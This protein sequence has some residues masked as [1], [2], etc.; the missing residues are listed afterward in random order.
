MLCADLPEYPRRGLRRGFGEGGRRA[1]ALPG[2]RRAPVGCANLVGGVRRLHPPGGLRHGDCEGAGGA[3]DLRGHRRPTWCGECAARRVGDA[4]GW[5]RVRGVGQGRGRRLRPLPGPGQQARPGRRST[6]TGT[7]RA[8]ERR[9][10][11]RD[12]VGLAGE[13]LVPAERGSHR[14]G[15]LVEHARAGQPR[16]GRQGSGVLGTEGRRQQTAADEHPEERARGL[17][18]CKARDRFVDHVC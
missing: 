9:P 1:R 6:A 2:Y 4:A 5:Q 12:P 13:G 11:S 10:R 7:G 8:R 17:E 16:E 14:R 3:H 15:G 18:E